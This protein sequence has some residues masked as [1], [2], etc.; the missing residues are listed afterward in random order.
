MNR[1]QVT[2]DNQTKIINRV[3]IEQLQHQADFLDLLT[4]F[5]T[6]ASNECC[7]RLAQCIKLSQELNSH[8]AK[9][10]DELNLISSKGE[11]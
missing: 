11:R 9:I 5:A 1:H 3:A 10:Q 7:G 8:L 6:E 4:A 2:K